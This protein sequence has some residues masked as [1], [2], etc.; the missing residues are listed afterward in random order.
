MAFMKFLLFKSEYILILK[1]SI[2]IDD[3]ELQYICFQIFYVALQYFFLL[4][5][6]IKD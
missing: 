3:K 5:F 4:R 6:Q 2:I 1:F